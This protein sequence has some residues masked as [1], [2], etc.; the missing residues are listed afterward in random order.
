MSAAGGLEP[1]D[2]DLGAGDTGDEE[3]GLSV[4]GSD[5]PTIES[6][7]NPNCFFISLLKMFGGWT[8]PG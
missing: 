2:H 4:S 8:R 3:P 5:L 1:G 6:M 7:L